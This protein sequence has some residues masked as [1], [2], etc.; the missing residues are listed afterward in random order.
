M[1][2]FTATGRLIES[3]YDIQVIS[4]TVYKC[5]GCGRTFRMTDMRQPP[6]GLWPEDRARFI[7]LN[8]ARALRHADRCKG[9][10]KDE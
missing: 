3:N 5:R 4:E 6:R 9:K 2:R 7:G 10:R 8:R 1:A